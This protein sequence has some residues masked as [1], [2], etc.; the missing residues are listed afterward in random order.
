[1]KLKSL[2]DK[3]RVIHYGNHYGLRTYLLVTLQSGIHIKILWEDKK[4][5]PRQKWWDGLDAEWTTI[6]D[7]FK[8]E[9]D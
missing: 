8:K 1:M 2:K 6:E 5:I 7:L 4:N 9:K 3:T